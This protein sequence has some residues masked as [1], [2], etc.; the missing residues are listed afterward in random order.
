MS[1]PKQQYQLIQHTSAWPEVI[2]MSE[3]CFM[4]RFASPQYIFHGTNE[5]RL[6]DFFNHGQIVGNKFYLTRDRK[7]AVRYGKTRQHHSVPIVLV[8][9]QTVMM[10]SYFEIMNKLKRARTQAR[11]DA[12]NE[13]IPEELKENIIRMQYSLSGYNHY[14]I[15][16]YE[17]RVQLL[18]LY[19]N[20]VAIVKITSGRSRRC[21]IS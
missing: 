4:K 3:S 5:R 19:Q 2:E 8:F 12:I 10:K 13:S 20:I 1:K 7:E 15:F 6:V 11:V 14:V 9:D 17:D 18:E 16:P 21:I